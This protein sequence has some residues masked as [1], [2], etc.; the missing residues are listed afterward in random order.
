MT[1]LLIPTRN[2]P[3]SLSN[4]LRYLARFYPSTWVIVADGSHETHQMRNR[5]TIEA[6]K[7]DLAVDYRPYPTEKS[8]VDRMLDVLRSESS[9]LV[10]VGSDDD[11]PVM[12]TLGQGEAFLHQNKDFSLAMGMLVNLQLNSPTELVAFPFIARS[13]QGEAPH[14]RAA[15]YANWPFPTTYAVGRRDVV[16]ERHERA[17]EL[18][19]V[20][21]F[22]WSSGVH[23]CLRGKIK[24][25]PEV[26]FI[27][28][29]NYKHSYLRPEAEL[30]FLRRSDE[31]LQIT[32]RF[33]R[34]LIRY[35]GL[36]EEEAKRRGEDL[37][38]AFLREMLGR[39]MVCMRGFE[40]KAMFA[41]PIVQKQIDIFEE[42]FE[43]GT[44]ARERYADRL[45]L[46]LSD[47]KANAASDDNTGE[48]HHYETLDEQT[49][50]QMAFAISQEE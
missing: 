44:P 39:P 31:V 8:Y 50:A 7:G 23:D 15:F 19:H 1:P 3:T 46:I 34:D 25:L 10:I 32:D 11:Y 5:Q 13:I 49:S 14:L 9:E 27:C 43:K 6:I 48:K 18:F 16:I 29:R 41:N 38:K 4:V 40:Q 33:R 37:M 24:A 12:E 36:A 42:L 47:I 26:G 30:V 17:R 35:A 2:R 28:T 45:A 22:D 21:L 20:V